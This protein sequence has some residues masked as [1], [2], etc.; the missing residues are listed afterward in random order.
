MRA[1]LASLVDTL[2]EGE[3]SHVAP[4]LA[5]LGE[6]SELSGVEAY[7]RSAA[8]ADAQV[9]GSFVDSLEAATNEILL[10][11][12]GLRQISMNPPVPVSTGGTDAEPVKSDEADRSDADSSIRLQHEWLQKPTRRSCGLIVSRVSAVVSRIRDLADRDGDGP[13]SER[14]LATCCGGIV[15]GIAYVHV[16]LRWAIHR[17]LTYRC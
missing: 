4:L 1:E 17:S 11:V 12:Q 8:S 2:S 3:A 16:R 9:I 13:D 6:I 7:G 5:K 15:G 10:A 14:G